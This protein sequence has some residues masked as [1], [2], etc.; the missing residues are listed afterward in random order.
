MIQQTATLDELNERYRPL[1]ATIE[2]RALTVEYEFDPDTGKVDG[3]MHYKL[4]GDYKYTAKYIGP[5]DALITDH[6]IHRNYFE[7]KDQYILEY[8]EVQLKL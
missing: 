6:W 2:I 8:S 3:Y 4:T 1:K 5:N 7:E